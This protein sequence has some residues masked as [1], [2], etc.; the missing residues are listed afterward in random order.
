M[1]S[2]FSQSENLF[3]FELEPHA[4]LKLTRTLFSSEDFMFFSLH[5]LLSLRDFICY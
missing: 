3:V 5:L 4:Y 2:S 1:I